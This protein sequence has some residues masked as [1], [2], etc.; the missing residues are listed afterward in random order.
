[1]ISIRRKNIVQ[2]VLFM[3]VNKIFDAF[4][5]NGKYLKAS[6][7]KNII[8]FC[9]THCGLTLCGAVTYSIENYIFCLH[10]LT[11]RNI[12]KTL[13]RFKK[14]LFICTAHWT[15]FYSFNLARKCCW[16]V[17]SYGNFFIAVAKKK[18]KKKLFH[19]I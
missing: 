16:F 7:F 19:A 4:N 15:F 9:W 8:K 14:E 10:C 3:Q 12:W 6:F 13:N 18:W 2:H 11:S 5:C 17:K 1:M